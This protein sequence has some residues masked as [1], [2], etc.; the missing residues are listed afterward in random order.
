MAA[1]QTFVGSVIL[2]VTVSGHFCGRFPAHAL[3][4]RTNYTGELGTIGYVWIHG[5]LR[6]RVNA[7]TG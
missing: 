3:I 7:V 1:R 2:I 6:H 5:S 4:P